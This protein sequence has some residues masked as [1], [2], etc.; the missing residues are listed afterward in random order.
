MRS[1][2]LF[3]FF[4]GLLLVSCIKE[5][6]FEPPEPVDPNDSCRLV[7]LVQGKDTVL[8]L[9]YDTKGRL[10]KLTDYDVPSNYTDSLLALFDG[11]NRVIHVTSDSPY[12]LD[13]FYEYAGTRIT[14]MKLVDQYAIADSTVFTFEYGS[15]PKPIRKNLFSYTSFTT[16]GLF[17]YYVFEY[18]PNGNISSKKTFSADNQLYQ[19]VVFTYTDQPNSFKSL[20]YFSDPFNI[21]DMQNAIDIEACW[22]EQDAETAVFTNAAGEIIRQKRITY[23][24]DAKNRIS[25]VVSETYYTTPGDGP[26]FNYEFFYNCQ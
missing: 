24:K 25:N 18:D 12:P 7:K 16:G 21:F 11:S 10:Y 14:K 23:I 3:A 17:E 19:T 9:F 5:K 1:I 6:S 4:T 15:G 26:S 8:S 13:V 2:F 20:S 22:N